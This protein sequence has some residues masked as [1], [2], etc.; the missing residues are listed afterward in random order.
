V[1]TTLHSTAES[2]VRAAGGSP[3]E[4]RDDRALDAV[5]GIRTTPAEAQ[6]AARIAAVRVVPAD[7]RGAHRTPTAGKVRT[8]RTSH[9]VVGLTSETHHS[10]L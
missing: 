5:Q 9:E 3:A 1:R 4:D 7:A 10:R 6:Y 8:I 2:V